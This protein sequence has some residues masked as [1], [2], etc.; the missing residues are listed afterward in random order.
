MDALTLRQI[1]KEEIATVKESFSCELASIK[2][3]IVKQTAE[4]TGNYR[5]ELQQMRHE[6]QAMR[7]AVDEKFDKFHQ[8]MA[9]FNIDGSR[10]STTTSQQTF[11]SELSD[12][13]QS[14]PD[15]VWT[16]NVAAWNAQTGA[17]S[18]APGADVAEEPA[19][20]APQGHSVPML[21]EVPQ[22]DNKRCILC[23]GSFKHKRGARQHMMKAFHPNAIC[24]FIPGYAPHEQILEPFARAVIPQSGPEAVWKLAVQTIMR[25]KRTN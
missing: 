24:K 4:L 20:L 11:T 7:Q 18:W 19:A 9:Q 6:H 5:S 23:H 3:S 16:G 12:G 21:P 15:A 13:P 25:S 22:R 17:P 2:D 1:L 10:P 14:L 8:M